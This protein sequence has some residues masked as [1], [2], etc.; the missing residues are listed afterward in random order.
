MEGFWLA[1]WFADPAHRA[2]AKSAMSALQR[3]MAKGVLK[4]AV[5]QTFDLG[6]VAGALACAA[7]P[8]RTGNVLLAGAWLAHLAWPLEKP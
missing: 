7:K 3:L 8:H 2:A 5:Q 1:S 6:Q 4:M